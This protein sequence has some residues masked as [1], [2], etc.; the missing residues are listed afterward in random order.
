M[1]LSEE[2]YRD[3]YIAYRFYYGKAFH[4]ANL[5]GYGN[6]I[7]DMDIQLYSD[8]VCVQWEKFN[9]W[10][11][12]EEALESFPISYLFMTDEQIRANVLIKESHV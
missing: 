10:G 12:R 4:I 9:R 11:D 7:S 5:L 8:E 1:N 3:M 6:E 2:A